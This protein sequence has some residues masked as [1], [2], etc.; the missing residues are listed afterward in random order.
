MGMNLL[1]DGTLTISVPRG[2]E[3]KRVLVEEEGTQFGS[4]FYPDREVVFC[5][6]CDRHNASIFDEGVGEICPLVQ[7]RGKAQGHEF[8]YQFCVYGRRKDG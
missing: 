8:D 2:T 3:V 5:K 7:Y 1:Q 6:D 4:L